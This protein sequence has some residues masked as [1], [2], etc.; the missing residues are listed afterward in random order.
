MLVELLAAELEA[1]DEAA[2]EEAVLVDAEDVDL[3]EAAAEL[4]W[5][6]DVLAP[7]EVVVVESPLP[8]PPPHAARKERIQAS[9]AQDGRRREN[10]DVCMACKKMIRIAR[11]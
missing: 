10:G 4:P 11:L 2:L 3:E 9:V 8:P 7:D 1:F 5:L 6:L